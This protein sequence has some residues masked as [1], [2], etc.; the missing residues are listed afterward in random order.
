MLLAREFLRQAARALVGPTQRRLWITAGC[1]LDQACARP[2]PGSMP[3][4]CDESVQPP[5]HPAYSCYDR[6]AVF[7]QGQFDQFIFAQSLTVG[8]EALR[9]PD[10]ARWGVLA[11]SFR[12]LWPITAFAILLR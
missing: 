2:S 10:A 11:P 3:E 5:L 7:E 8:L 1:R 12:F 6:N 4:T 9:N